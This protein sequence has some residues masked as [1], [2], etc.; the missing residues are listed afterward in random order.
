VDHHHRGTGAGREAAPS[1]GSVHRARRVP[2][3]FLYVRADHVGRRNDQRRDSRLAQRRDSR[4][5]EGVH[6]CE[7]VERGD[8]SADERQSLPLRLL[9]Q[10]RRRRGRC[11]GEELNHARLGLSPADNPEKAIAA[12]ADDARLAFIAGALSR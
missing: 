4:R 7:P 5:D 2:V 1:L 12:Q 3:P 11:D 9:S 10:H 6:H 8:P